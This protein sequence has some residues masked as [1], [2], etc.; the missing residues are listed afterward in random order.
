MAR[1]RNA[2]QLNAFR[3]AG[4]TAFLLLRRAITTP[5]ARSG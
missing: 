3:V 1:V 4:T 5:S 2:Q